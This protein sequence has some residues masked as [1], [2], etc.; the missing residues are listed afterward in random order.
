[1]NPFGQYKLFDNVIIDLGERSDDKDSFA[2]PEIEQ[3]AERCL[4]GG[5]QQSEDVQGE[6]QALAL[7][8]MMKQKVQGTKNVLEDN[9]SCAGKN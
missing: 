8:S 4:R 5:V 1:M 6:K 3:K 2:T 7:V 9:A